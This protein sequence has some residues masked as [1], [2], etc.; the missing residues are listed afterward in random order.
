MDRAIT[1]ELRNV[2]LG[3]REALREIDDATD[4]ESLLAAWHKMQTLGWRLHELLPAL[5]DSSTH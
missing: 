5:E 2:Y 3:Y 1:M 4:D